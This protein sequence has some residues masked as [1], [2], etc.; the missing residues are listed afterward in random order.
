MPE[1]ATKFISPSNTRSY[2]LQ[3]TADPAKPNLKKTNVLSV[4]YYLL[5][6]HEENSAN[7]TNSAFVAVVV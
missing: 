2:S 4:T 3:F 7:L 6:A 5:P 1:S